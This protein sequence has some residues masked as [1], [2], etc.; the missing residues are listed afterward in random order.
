[1]YSDGGLYM[2]AKTF[3]ECP[4]LS[5][6][7]DLTK[8]Q[9]LTYR[10]SP[11][12]VLDLAIGT[13]NKLDWKCSTCE[14]E[15]RAVGKSRVSGRGCPACAGR[16]HSDGRNSMFNTHPELAKEY[17]GDSNLII[18]GTHKKL[19]WKCITCKHEWRTTGDKRF[20][21]KGCPSCVNLAVNS[22]DG[23]NSMTNT[24][25]QLAK[26]YQG[27][28]NLIIAGTHKKLDWKCITC[29]HEWNSQ[30]KS[31]SQGCGCPACAGRLHSDGRNSMFN[32]HPHLAIDYQGDAKLIIA[33]TNETLGWKCSTCEHDW[34]SKGANRVQGK[35]CPAC[36]GQVIHSDGRNSMANT[37]PQLAKEYQGDA[38]L[39]MAGTHT[40]LDW[41]CNTCE[42]EW[43]AIGNNRFQ[44]NGC[45]ACVNQ[46]LHSDGLNSMFNTHPNL[47]KE[48]QGDA[49]SIIAGTGKKLDWKCVTCEHE[50]RAGG[51]SRTNGSGCPACAKSGYDPSKIGYVYIHQYVD[52]KTHWLK[53]GITN[54]PQ[55][56]HTQLIR[57]A[58]R[59]N[60]E[61]QQLD[62]YTFD[63]GWVAQ[64]CER[65]LLNKLELRFNSEYDIDGKAEFFKYDALDEI[66]CVVAKYL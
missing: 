50:W 6:E 57:A 37:H 28:A 55:Q 36:A 18:A 15:W 8:N 5:V 10:G 14:H 22:F 45:P 64:T 42:H 1:M 16:L 63:D 30:C 2:S 66:K 48:Y 31:R 49:Q 44:G 26:E 54:H 59:V 65:E 38:N 23:R 53:C 29:E 27:D 9:D 35:G 47:A 13:H 52:K 4:E 43:R 51:N 11:I 12:D 41:K 20:Q 21:G 40:T 19:D 60:I 61:V 7:L 62:I 24:H 46:R 17:Q 3:R 33:G 34:K 39:I 58:S 56:R 25:P 32:T